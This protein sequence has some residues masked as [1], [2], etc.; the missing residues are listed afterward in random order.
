[1]TTSVS[2]AFQPASFYEAEGI[3]QRRVPSNPGSVSS[4]NTTSPQNDIPSHTIPALPSLPIGSSAASSSRRAPEPVVG[5]M[6]RLVFDDNSVAMFCG[7]STGVHFISQAE[8]QLQMLRV[9]TETLPSSTYGLHLHSPWGTSLLQGSD[10]D[11]HLLASMVSRLPVEA[12]AIIEATVDRWTPLY[13]ILHKPSARE[14]YQRLTEGSATPPQGQ[15]PVLD[16]YQTLAL[17]A[18]GTL[19]QP[20]AA[21]APDHAHFLCV[22]ETYY[23]MA[24]AL[25]DRVMSRPCLQ[26]LQGMEI[27]QI[28]LQLSARYSV[29]SH[30]GGVAV[31]LAQTL[32]LHRHSHRFK[33]DPL[34]TELRRR[35]WWCQYTLDTFSSAYHGMP[36]L[37]RDQDVDTDLPT[38]VDH[39]LLT[40]SHVAFPLPGE[41]S[42]V[43]TALSLVKLAR[44]MGETLERLYTTTRRRGGVSK[45]AR[46]QAELDRWERESLPGGP[47]AGEL[48][49]DEPATAS[50][51]FEVTFLRVALSV[52]TIHVHRPALAFTT[53]D[54]QFSLSLQACVRASTILI[55]LLSSEE[56]DPEPDPTS[57]SPCYYHRCPDSIFALLLYPSGAHMLWQAGLTLIFARCKGTY[58]AA[59]DEDGALVAKCAAA[60]RSLHLRTC[61][62]SS[63][64][65]LSQA[66]DVLDTLCIK[67]FRGSSGSGSGSGSDNSQPAGTGVIE[68]LQWN[69]WDWP[70]ASALE[71]ANTLDAA[72]FDLYLEPDTWM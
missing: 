7:S 5:H 4:L 11:S 14:A 15:H 25:L 53:A 1:M 68:Q 64:A 54:P 39:D 10:D 24:T 30:L 42:Q 56:A 72:P 9:H 32:G 58:I 28:Y 33:F 20:A 13:P 61:A 60:L 51:S 47:E 43:D 55:R 36:R 69:V 67:V 27:M 40:R 17:L 3:E 6:G 31:R 66:A 62:G 65:S 52:A 45:I 19:G 57:E 26:T 59:A 16:L 50:A 2:P 21:C 35:V 38:R 12:G 37:I 46:L 41:V 8:Q 49:D 22:S 34:E 29:A 71:L 70:M 44:I 48:D 63:G 23:S 18:L